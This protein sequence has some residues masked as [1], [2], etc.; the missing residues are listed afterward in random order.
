MESQFLS[1]SPVCQVS[2]VILEWQLKRQSLPVE[3]KL[4]L[5]KLQVSQVS[6]SGGIDVQ[7]NNAWGLIHWVFPQLN[8]A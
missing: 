3:E 4:G 7:L 2:E 5:I 1:L 6:V 8:Q